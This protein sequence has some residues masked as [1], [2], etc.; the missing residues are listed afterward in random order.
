MGALGIGFVYMD[1][2]SVSDILS[3]VGMT[4]EVVGQGDLHEV[5]FQ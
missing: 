5:F 1:D 3:N 2:I 4:L